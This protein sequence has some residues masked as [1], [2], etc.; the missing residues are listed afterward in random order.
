VKLLPKKPGK[1]LERQA[2]VTIP[3]TDFAD[4]NPDVDSYGVIVSIGWFDPDKRQA[5]DVKKCTVTLKSITKSVLDHDTFAEEWRFKAGVNGRWIHREF[6]GMGSN[7]TRA[8]NETFVIH[9][10]Q[11][12]FISVTSHGAEVD[13]VDDVYKSDRMV[14]LSQRDI[15]EVDLVGGDV[16]IGGDT[17]QRPI[18]WD[19][20]VDGN[21]NANGNALNGSLPVQRAICRKLF[22]LMFTTFGDQNDPLG[23]I[24][25]G[26]GSA[27]EAK[28]NPRRVRDVIAEKGEGVEETIELQAMATS[29]VGS[30]AELVRVD[31]NLPPPA[32]EPSD[33]DYKLVYTIKVEPQDGL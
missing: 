12:D 24:D 19:R 21:R 26:R 3:L 22:D 9:L 18:D 5:K 2:K 4:E 11:D 30:S 7:D 6:N 1:P 32:L 28:L 10:H 16:P 15:N 23:M 20:D 17:T 27:A 31:P 8:L 29:E 33:F 25:P 13:L 14:T